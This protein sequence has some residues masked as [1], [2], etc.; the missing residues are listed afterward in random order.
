MFLNISL[1]ILVL[2]FRLDLLVVT[3]SLIT[4]EY[5]FIPATGYLDGAELACGPV[6]VHDV[7]APAYLD[8]SESHIPAQTALLETVREEELLLLQVVD[9][10]PEEGLPVLEAAVLG[11]LNVRGLPDVLVELPR[12]DLHAVL[13]VHLEAHDFVQHLDFGVEVDLVGDR[14]ELHEVLAEVV[15]LLELVHELVG[16]LVHP[17]QHE[18][19]AVGEVGMA[20]HLV[21]LQVEFLLVPEHQVDLGPAV[22]PGVGLELEL[23]AAVELV[24][25]QGEDVPVDF[26]HA[27]DV[28]VDLVEQAQDVALLGVGLLESEL[29]LAQVVQLAVEQVVLDDRVDGPIQSHGGLHEAAHFLLDE[30]EFFIDEAVAHFLLVALAFLHFA[31]DQLEW[32]ILFVL[33]F[34]AGDDDVP[35]GDVIDELEA[36]RGVVIQHVH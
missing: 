2:F 19:L 32:A 30:L 36:L 33:G 9:V 20:V 7:A 18:T 15:V 21:G 4:N 31:E 13:G 12:E 6:G 26:E 16:A 5:K 10:R 14:R 35:Q 8:V 29:V 24:P 1:Q 25:E 28:E 27:L 34:V 17:A 3:L 22:V 11:P 23:L